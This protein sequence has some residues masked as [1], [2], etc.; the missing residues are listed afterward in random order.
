MSNARLILIPVDLGGSENPVDWIGAQLREAVRPL[1]R[2]VV[3]HPKSARQFLKRLGMPLQELQLEVLDE[4]SKAQDLDR[5]SHWLASGGDAGLLSEAGCPAIADPGAALVR[6]AHE[7]GILVV[8]LVGPSSIVMALMASGLNGQR[9][10]FN[11]YLP[12]AAE[13]RD[14]GIRGLEDRSRRLDETEIFIEAPYRNDALFAAILANCRSDSLLSIATDLTT[15]TEAITTMTIGA[16]RRA[17][18]PILHKRPTVFLLLAGK[19]GSA[20][21]RTRTTG[22]K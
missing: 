9:F 14:A 18:A 3:E 1:R 15:P 4:H 7:L 20:H 17:A 21:G 12:Q 16:W 22:V 10:A 6:R 2:F 13:A 8:P 5:L 19:P 11:G